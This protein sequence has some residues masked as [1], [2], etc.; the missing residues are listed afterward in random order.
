MFI[1]LTKSAHKGIVMTKKKMR[2]LRRASTPWVRGFKLSLIRWWV[3]ARTCQ[4]AP[5]AVLPA[6]D[7]A[8]PFGSVLIIPNLVDCKRK[9]K[10]RRGEMGEIL[11]L[12]SLGRIVGSEARASRSVCPVSKVLCNP[13]VNYGAPELQFVPGVCLLLGPL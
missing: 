2:L 13:L 12:I 4:H 11:A 8:L 3:C 7:V 9:K 1:I 5:Q 6:E 10:K